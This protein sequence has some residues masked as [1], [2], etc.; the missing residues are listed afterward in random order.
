MKPQ[1]QAKVLHISII[2]LLLLSIIFLSVGY[3]IAET[4]GM[5]SCALHVPGFIQLQETYGFTNVNVKVCFEGE[6]NNEDSSNNTF[7]ALCNPGQNFAWSVVLPTHSFLY[8]SVF[9]FSFCC[10]ASYHAS[11]TSTCP[12]KTKSKRT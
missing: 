1:I 3:S 9:C 8:R 12:L 2:V 6:V 5:T 10:C 11:G 7:S 4:Q